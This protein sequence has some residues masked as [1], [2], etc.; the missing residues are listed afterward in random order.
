MSNQYTSTMTELEKT[1]TEKETRA[2]SKALEKSNKSLD[3]IRYD[4]MNLA[5]QYKDYDLKKKAQTESLNKIN[6]EIQSIMTKG[7]ALQAMEKIIMANPNANIKYESVTAVRKENFTNNE[8]G[9]SGFSFNHNY[10]LS[11]FK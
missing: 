4:L 6:I 7:R 5:K 8:S 3:A 2:V 1:A 9:V 11:S 10:N